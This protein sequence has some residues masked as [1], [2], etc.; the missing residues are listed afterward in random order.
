VLYGS[1][2]SL[3]LIDLER[4]V[5][6][7]DRYVGGLADVSAAVFY[8]GDGMARLGSRGGESGW[9]V[10]GGAGPE[11][12]RIPIDAY[13]L[14]SP[15]GSLVAFT[16]RGQVGR[17]FMGP[18]GAATQL[19]LGGVI[20]AWTWAPDGSAAYVLVSNI[21]GIASLMHVSAKSYQANMI[22]D[23]LDTHPTQDAIGIS[24]DG[25]RL[26]LALASEGTP[27]PTVRHQPIADRDQDIYELALKT[28]KLS[29][30]V[31]G[32][33]DDFWPGVAGGYLYWTHNE[34]SQAAVVVPTAGGE[35]R[36]VVEG[37]Q[38][39]YWSTDGRRLAYTFGGGRNVDGPLG[40]DVAMVDIDAEGRATSE[41]VLLV[42]GTH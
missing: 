2:N 23:G 42:V 21:D 26:Y 25:T 11:L 5:E 4:G 35:A 18:P 16:R 32:P 14:W 31:R 30:L 3:R 29:A 37:A 34:L 33:G 9:F 8:R 38:I 10:D 28:G 24:A 1:G 7:R 13:P 15:D 40:L 6:D 39:P 27:D 20:T 22:L 36:V 17:F 19:D 12:S 41:P